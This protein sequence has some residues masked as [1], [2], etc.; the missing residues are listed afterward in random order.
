MREI[1]IA[2][3]NKGKVPE[4]A[5]GLA[6]LGLE[7]KSVLDVPA[8]EGFEPEETGNTFEANAEIKAAEYGAK[9]HMITIAD[10]SGLEI[11]ALH[12]EPGIRSARY[13]E[14]A[15]VDRYRAV[16]AKMQDIPDERRTARFVSVIALYDPEADK[17][18]TTRGEC[19]G[20]ILHEPKGEHGFG[21]DPIFFADGIGKTF[22]EATLEEK[23]SVDHRG[24]ALLQM[25]AMIEREY[26]HN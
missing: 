15:D 7:F 3:R 10:D 4:I 13:V 5:A 11:D 2:T 24:K 22:G 14:G 1:L 16:L 18:L 8:L 25:R 26:P 21:Y 6:G 23:Q 20:R 19:A 17:V 9:A 12:G